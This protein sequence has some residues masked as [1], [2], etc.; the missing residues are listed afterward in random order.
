MTKLDQVRANIAARPDPKQ[1]DRA[2][3][4]F[5]KPQ[6]KPPSMIDWANSK[7]SY[8]YL[9]PTI[10]DQLLHLE[11]TDLLEA[12]NDET[13]DA[14]VAMKIGDVG[15]RLLKDAYLE[16]K[17]LPRQHFQSDGLHAKA[18][19]IISLPRKLLEASM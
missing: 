11:L 13:L 16:S 2:P 14:I 18:K 10:R 12:M 1:F 6:Y 8:S 7:H 17:Q 19:Q 9:P 15:S 5:S 3:K 4:Q